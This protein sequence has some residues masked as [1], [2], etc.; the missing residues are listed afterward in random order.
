MQ[1][2]S[3]SR[4][5][6]GDALEKLDEIRDTIHLTFLDPPYNQGKSYRFFNDKQSP[7]SYWQWIDDLLSKI[8]KLTAEG[9]C[10]YF[11]Q[12]EKNT[13]HVLR[14][15][16]KTGWTFQNLI[17]W[18]KRTSAVPCSWRYGK[19]YQIIAFATK[20]KKPR[21]FNK[22][23]VD[24]PLRPEYK[25][26]RE[27]GIFV[28][29]VWDDI[30]ELTSGFFAGD[31]ALRDKEGK[32]L[33]EQ[34]SPVALLLRIILSSTHIGDTVLDPLAGTGVTLVVAKQLQRNYIG[35][36]IDP[37]YVEIIKQRLSSTR[38]PDDIHKYY[39][40]YRYTPNLGEIWKP[41]L[42]QTKLIEEQ[43]A[44]LSTNCIFKAKEQ[45]VTHP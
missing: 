11:M 23:R 22:L 17:I 19:Q 1:N 35:I 16:R 8:Y 5:I 42:K 9:G 25:L 34:Q 44:R 40:Y 28:T 45:K 30:K 21:V 24:Y 6:E 7:R 2:P 27:D 26:P 31:E 20:G 12:R 32:R 3:I 39:D 4:I 14:S 36:E 15:L 41:L 29:D 13:E 43:Q 33:H 18:K 37:N 10:I 38:D